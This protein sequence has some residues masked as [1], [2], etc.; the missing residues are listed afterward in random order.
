M[1]QKLCMSNLALVF[2]YLLIL[3]DWTIYIIS[4]D[5]GFPAHATRSGV[6]LIGGVG[7]CVLRLNLI[8]DGE[9]GSDCVSSFYLRVLCVKSEGYVVFLFNLG[10]LM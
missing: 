5:A 4:F 6:V 10:S 2:T 9:E 3:C 8:C 7:A 1:V